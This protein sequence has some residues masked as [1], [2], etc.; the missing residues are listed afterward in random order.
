MHQAA[1]QELAA[2][3]VAAAFREGSGR[4]VATLTRQF[5]DLALAEECVQDAF[6]AACRTW[7]EQG[8]PASPVGWI[9]SSARNAAIDR[10]RRESTR[11]ARH[12]EA[13]QRLQSEPP[14]S[15]QTAMDDQLRLIFTCC[16]PA[17]AET[18][19]VAL[20]LRLVA[21][22][23]TPEIARAFLLPEPTLAQRIVR[24]KHRIADAQIPYRVPDPEELPERLSAVLSV[25]YLVFNEGYVA[26]GG[27]QLARDELTVEAIRLARLLGR[28]LPDEPEAQGLLALM[29]LTHARRR[30]RTGADGELIPL[31]AQDRSLWDRDALTEGRA[32]L[33]A[34]LEQGKPG[35][36]QIQAAIAAVHG[37]AIV[38]EDTDW[39]QIVA[40]YDQLLL[41]MP[42]PVVAMNR[43]IAVGELAGPKA[44]LDLL[45]PL[46]LERYYLWHACRAQLLQRLGCS[47]AAVAAYDRALELTDN[48]RERR[49]LLD[50]RAACTL[51]RSRRD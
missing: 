16:H 35:P 33:R 48:G 25:L 6:V 20:T 9:L 10:L 12:E 47:D 13:M 42:T 4:A 15:E 27:E 45:E 8:I 28:L 18:A 23:Q 22:L 38:A 31:A 34:G 29:L 36:Y 11:E 49:L 46:D 40:L 14:D 44:A 19:Q 51:D 17:L 43:A 50:R 5:R 26:T 30:A 41:F 21:G 32:V 24:A 1:S 3:E 2:R 37:D 7:P 39:T